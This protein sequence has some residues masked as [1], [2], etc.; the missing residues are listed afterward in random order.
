MMI[1]SLVIMKNPITLINFFGMSVA[2]TG[3]FLYNQAK[4][5]QDRAKELLL[6]VNSQA[7]SQIN[8]AKFATIFLRN[9]IPMMDISLTLMVI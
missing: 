1:I 6:Y 4:R 5:E 3:V 2:V 8:Y 7:R 9:S